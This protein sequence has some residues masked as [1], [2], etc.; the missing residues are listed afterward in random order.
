MV[1]PAVEITSIRVITGTENDPFAKIL[2]N[3]L[4]GLG[5]MP[6]VRLSSINMPTPEPTSTLTVD[7]QGISNEEVILRNATATIRDGGSYLPITLFENCA[8]VGPLTSGG[9]S[10][11][12]Q[13]KTFQSQTQCRY[14]QSANNHTLAAEDGTP[15]WQTALAA[16]VSAEITRIIPHYVQKLPSTIGSY[17]ELDFDTCLASAHSLAQVDGCDLCAIAHERIF[18]AANSSHNTNSL[19]DF[20]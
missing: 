9:I 12:I 11:C 14:H 16:V 13:C 10:A 5:I 17:I 19:H 1:L 20:L 3:Q 7:V 6:E 18:Q 15:P 4:R 2:F 8:Q